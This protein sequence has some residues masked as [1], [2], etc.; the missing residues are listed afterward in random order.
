MIADVRLLAIGFGCLVI[1]VGIGVVVSG[2]IGTFGAAPPVSES[3]ASGSGDVSA[4]EQALATQ[5]A[6]FAAEAG[7]HQGGRAQ[8]TAALSRAYPGLEVT[9]RTPEAGQLG[10]RVV[11]GKT[12]LCIG[13]PLIWSC[14]Y[15][16]P[17]SAPASAP[18]LAGARAALA[19]G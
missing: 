8:V 11:G 4:D 6:A 13:S 18:T 17:D 9:D 7:N 10:V 15:A 14:R 12:E 1:C 3:R 19:R 16:R 5:L 2:T